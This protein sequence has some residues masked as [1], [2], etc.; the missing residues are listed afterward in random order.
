MTD[1]VTVVEHSGDYVVTVVVDAPDY[2]FEA[3]ADTLP[4]AYRAAIQAMG[5]MMHALLPDQALI[6][7]A[8]YHDEYHGTSFYGF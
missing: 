2:V 3:R 7:E 1:I 8:E 5:A 6:H 4:K